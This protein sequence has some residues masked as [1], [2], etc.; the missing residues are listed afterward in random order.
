M[1]EMKAAGSDGVQY[2]IAAGALPPHQIIEY[3]NDGDAR[4]VAE[5]QCKAMVEDMRINLN[6]QDKGKSKNKKKNLRNTNRSPAHGFTTK[7]IASASLTNENELN[8]EIFLYQK[9]EM[10]LETEF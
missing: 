1:K 9:N 5:L 3:V 10:G 2:K 8:S 4:Q 7:F 6:N